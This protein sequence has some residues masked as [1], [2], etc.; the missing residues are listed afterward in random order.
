MVLTLCYDA[1][2]KNINGTGLSPFL[3]FTIT[4]ST[5]LPACLFILMVQD[6]VG[7]KA[8]A[9]GSLAV[10]GIIS[11]CAGV[12]IIF[13]SNPE[14]V[15]LLVL[16]IMARLGINIAYNSGHQ[17]AVE[18]LPTVVRGQGVAVVHVVGYGA[19]FFSSNILYLAEI[20]RPAPEIV[21]GLTYFT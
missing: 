21:I 10:S 6:K 19:A 15:V 7:R 12:Y 5:I 18:L 8:L 14:P 9:S 17:Y 11:T 16:S 20:W 1:I 3:V 13:T 2:S 4:S